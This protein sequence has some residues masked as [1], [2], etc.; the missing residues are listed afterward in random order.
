MQNL[1]LK[2]LEDEK[3]LFTK[4]VW[5]VALPLSLELTKEG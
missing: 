2:T 4:K 3:G 5:N 1:L